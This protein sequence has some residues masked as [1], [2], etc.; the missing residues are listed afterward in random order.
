MIIIISI[1]LVLAFFY[2]QVSNQKIIDNN[3]G[4]M[5]IWDINEAWCNCV[6]DSVNMLNQSWREHIPKSVFDNEDFLNR[7]TEIW[8]EYC[9]DKSGVNNE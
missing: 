3:Y 1:I 4:C 8:N 7:Q 6:Q 5:R 9:S 2:I